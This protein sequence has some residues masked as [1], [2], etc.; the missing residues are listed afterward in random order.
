MYGAQF[1]ADKEAAATEALARLI[2][3]TALLE[4]GFDIE[5]PK[6]FNARIYELLG[7]RARHRAGRPR[8]VRGVGGGRRGG[9]APDPGSLACPTFLL[10]ESLLPLP[11]TLPCHN[12]RAPG[13]RY[14]AMLHSHD[15]IYVFPTCPLCR[16]Q[17]HPCR[18]HVISKDTMF[19]PAEGV[20]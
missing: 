1:E 17:A 7:A 16:A 6:E 13:L 12:P 15:F 10:W 2:W 5:A 19:Q 4:S 11:I 18:R 9:G 20:L 3:D 14:F 8:H